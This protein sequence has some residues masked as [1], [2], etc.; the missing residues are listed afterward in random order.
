[1]NKSVFLQEKYVRIYKIVGITAAVYLAFRYALPLFAPFIAAYLMA[2]TVRPVAA[3]LQRRLRI[4]MSVGGAITLLLA[5]AVLLTGVFFLGK[6]LVEQVMRFIENY[7]GYRDA[8]LRAAERFCSRV[9]GWFSLKSGT[10]GELMHTGLSRIGETVN[11]EML[12]ALSKRSVAMLGSF[13]YGVAGCIIAFV[14]AVLLLGDREKYAKGCRKS[15]FYE[16]AKQVMGRLSA[17]GVA[18]LKTQCILMLL[19]ALIC[20]VG[21]LFVKSEYALLLGIG[22]AILDAFPVLGS[23]LVLVPWALVCLLKG[24]YLQVAVLVV[25]YLLCLLVREGL[26]P[27]LLGNRIGIPPLYTLMA[28][29]VGVELF[30]ILGVILGPFGLVIIRAVLE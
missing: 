11:E 29:Y 12:P 9:D 24:N 30:G 3:F 16:E 2:A 15:P 26:E 27:K 10:A 23:G 14:A 18:Y 1:M 8:T 21:F 17:T 28:V 13:A 22:V 19:I 5:L 6:L 7:G 25:M 4:P 20:T